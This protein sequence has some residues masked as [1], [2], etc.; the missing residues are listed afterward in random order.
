MGNPEAAMEM[1]KKN[2]ALME[3]LTETERREAA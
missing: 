2:M 1:F 3:K